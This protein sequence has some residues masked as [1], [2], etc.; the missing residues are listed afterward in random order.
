MKLSKSPQL[1]GGD[2]GI[3]WYY[4]ER[5]HMVLMHQV[6]INSE[7]IRTDQIHIPWKMLAATMKRYK[8]PGR[9]RKAKS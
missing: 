2:D 9:K 6:W 8:T 1:I 4:E 7:L 3:N 5:G